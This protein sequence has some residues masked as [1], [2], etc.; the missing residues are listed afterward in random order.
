MLN[1]QIKWIGA[2]AHGVCKSN[3]TPTLITIILMNQNNAQRPYIQLLNYSPR[4]SNQD[5]YGGNRTTKQLK[6]KTTKN[7]WWLKSSARYDKSVCHRVLSS[8]PVALRSQSWRIWF[9]VFVIVIEYSSKQ[10]QSNKISCLSIL[11]CSIRATKHSK[12]E[13]QKSK[14]FSYHARNFVWWMQMANRL[15]VNGQSNIHCNTHKKKTPTDNM[16]S[17]EMKRNHI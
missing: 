13:R 15:M 10:K 9:F 11:C 2:T 17:T 14:C 5:S 7:E 3:E 8:K 6:K 12:C 4:Q 16:N 1:I